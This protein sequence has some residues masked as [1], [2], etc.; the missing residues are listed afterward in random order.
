M[1]LLVNLEKKWYLLSITIF[2]KLVAVGVDWLHEIE[3][4]RFFDL[5]DNDI[6]KERS[7]KTCSVSLG[8]NIM[9]MFSSRNS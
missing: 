5:L 7:V 4:L 9:F 3:S 8:S 2:I 1:T 6:G